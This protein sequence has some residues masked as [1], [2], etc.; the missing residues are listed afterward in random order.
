MRQA[1]PLATIS[2]ASGQTSPPISR[3]SM[4]HASRARRLSNRMRGAR[5]LRSLG[6]GKIARL[7]AANCAAVQDQLHR[8]RHSG[9][10]WSTWGSPTPRAA[11]HCWAVSGLLPGPIT[12]V[13][14]SKAQ[15]T[16]NA[17]SPARTYSPRLPQISHVSNTPDTAVSNIKRFRCRGVI[18]VPAKTNFAIQ[19]ACRLRLLAMSHRDSI[20]RLMNRFLPAPRRAIFFPDPEE[21]P[22]A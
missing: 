19:S 16:N 17:I 15:V 11:A 12:S 2:T 5:R 10:F 13:T 21:N 8:S 14:T 9:W 4:V 3:C 1:E 22:D 20:G 7:A 18:V 6:V